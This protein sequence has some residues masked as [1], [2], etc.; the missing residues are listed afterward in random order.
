VAGPG[1][2]DGGDARMKTTYKV[3]GST[4]FR[5]YAPGEEF[6]ADLTEEQERRA[7]ERGSI[8]VVKRNTPTK[9]E[10]EADE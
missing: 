10:E 2:H 7:K 9:K 1:D 5:G 3:V 4:Y 6:N 8:R